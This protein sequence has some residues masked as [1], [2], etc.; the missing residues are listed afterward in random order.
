[1]SFFM[2]ALCLTV[3]VRV[4]ASTQGCS[5]VK[6]HVATVT[7]VVSLVH[8]TKCSCRRRRLARLSREAT[9]HI[10][11]VNVTFSLKL[12]FKSTFP[13]QLC[14]GGVWSRDMFQRMNGFVCQQGCVHIQ[15]D[16]DIC[17]GKAGW[18]WT[19]IQHEDFDHAPWIFWH[20]LKV[21]KEKKKKV[22]YWGM[23]SHVTLNS[24]RA[25]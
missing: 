4:S 15:G 20:F 8:Y 23:H 24:R 10:L 25:H 18:G 9:Q 22:L 21:K 7:P 3:A 13:H 14:G 19:W 17:C 12:P 6:C 5:D 2:F 1:M 16:I 11:D